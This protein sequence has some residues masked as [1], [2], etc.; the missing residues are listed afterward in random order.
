[1]TRLNTMRF[2]SYRKYIPNLPIIKQ[3]LRFFINGNMTKKKDL[4]S[5]LVVFLLLLST[6]S[7]LF[8]KGRQDEVF[9]DADRLVAER[10]YVEA[11]IKLI[12]IV[13][14]DPSL[15][16]KVQKRL[17][18]I[19]RSSNR[20]TEI[21]SQLL[22]TIER[23]P[24]NAE[25]I[26]ELSEALD[27]LG[28]AR[29]REAREFI[30]NIQQVARYSVFN[31][32][33]EHI[34]VNGRLLIDED[35]YID[36][37]NL[38]LSGFSLYQSV[39]AA[40]DYPEN[41][42][43]SMNMT[44]SAI[45]SIAAPFTR[46]AER[47][48][49]V[50]AELTG[51][52]AASDDPLEQFLAVTRAVSRFQ[53]ELNSL[54]QTKN[55]V[56]DIRDAYRGYSEIKNS[57]EGRYYI[58]FG[59][60]LINGR[61]GA[62]VREG[63]LGVM[64]GLWGLVMRPLEEIAMT[65]ADSSFAGV[66]D[67]LQSHNYAQARR[68]IAS[69]GTVLRG[70][71]DIIAMNN[72][73]SERDDLG[74]LSVFGRSVK[75]TDASF[76]ALIESLNRLIPLL[77][78]AATYAEQ[79]D[80]AN[81]EM[82]SSTTLDDYRGNRIN[83]AQ[84]VQREIGIR[85]PIYELEANIRALMVSLEQNL[86]ELLPLMPFYD[87]ASRG[88]A[89]FRSA[90]AFSASLGGNLHAVKIASASRQY[91]VENEDFAAA[92]PQRRA[93]FDTGFALSDGILK[94][95][96]TGEDFLSKDP[97]EASLILN[98]LTATLS[99]DIT[100]GR[101]LL[102]RYDRENADIMNAG[103]MAAL[104]AEAASRLAQY[105]ALYAQS[106]ALAAD[107]RR[108]VAEAETLRMDGARLYQSAVSALEQTQ[109]DEA[110]TFLGR[111]DIQY[112][113]SLAIQD[114]DP[115]RAES[116]ERSLALSEEIMRVRRELIRREV[117]NLIA[118]AQP[119]FYANNYEIAEQLLVEAAARHATISDEENPDIRY[120][121]DIV[122]NA[123]SYR[124]GRILPITAPLYAEMSQLLSSAEMEYD[125]GMTL[126]D[127]RREEA[128]AYFNNARQKTHEVKLLFP[129][130][131]EANLL[132][133]RIDQVINPAAFTASFQERLNTAVSGTKRADVQAFADLQD[134]AAIDPNYR[135][136]TQI[137]YQ[138]EVDMG[139]RPPPP[140]EI[141]IAR[142]RDLTRVA[143]NLIA[144]GVRSNL[145]IAQGQLT[146]ALRVNPDNT[147]AEA[148]LDRVQRL[149]GRRAAS[150]LEAAVDNDYEEALRELLAGNKLIAYSIVRRIL[151]RPEYRNSGRFQELLQRIEAVL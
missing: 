142:S 23:D 72:S 116:R 48:Q 78:Q 76:Y 55:L 112:G 102:T 111:S 81:N 108:A 143:Q 125:A 45:G 101:A 131:Q 126:L 53:N 65:A 5:L 132:Q 57:G 86:N 19:V 92:Y 59:N 128:L 69:T 109:V 119:A 144:G 80:A 100:R 96:D 98:P 145:E 56:W 79:C 4:V 97:L 20:Y 24:G 35:R 61:P 38:Y 138:A 12:Q 42:K 27:E 67:A 134:L 6:L 74:D 123:L 95:L 84:A 89:L 51:L 31:N 83:A 16:D 105:E 85:V 29:T 41:A 107:S 18:N 47:I 117:E 68:L 25:K 46:Q 103:E 37:F 127:D 40:S 70:P 114:S 44:Q 14:D 93:Q 15:F 121:L 110:D 39:F 1:M 91:A 113:A 135:G 137:V 13:R 94:T 99:D 8:A 33:L 26:F 150:E 52:P 77:S 60:Q 106:V 49:E 7:P 82:L 146:E 147:T 43:F 21:A 120:W 118:R 54:V 133:L 136:I 28:A 11:I 17:Q 124:S 50:A 88:A 64:D 66:F 9:K 122:R 90:F 104:R 129:I 30:V 87:G 36:A 148:E 22:D 75:D 130:N 149:M 139:F 140:D 32:Q 151:A 63:L 62:D 3:T 34:L 115:L 71:L 141:A 73:L 58:T 10:N 2:N